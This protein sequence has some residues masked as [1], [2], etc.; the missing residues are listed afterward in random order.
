MKRLRILALMH[1]DL[2][3]PAD[4]TGADMMMVPWK[5]EYDVLSALRELGHEVLPLGVV[6]DLAQIRDAVEEVRPHIAFNLLEQ[7]DGHAIYDQ[8]V[9]AYLELLGVAYTGC[10]PRGL[11]LG[12]DKALSKKVLAYHRIPCPRFLVCRWG[13]TVRLPKRFSYPVIVK[14][15][16]EDS[17]WGISQAS[18]VHSDD[19]LQ[20]RV[21]FLQ[22]KTGDDAIIEQYIEG[23]ELYVSVVGNQRL[24]VFPVWELKLDELAADAYPIATERVKFNRSYREKYNIESCRADLPAELEARI[25]KL[26]KRVYRALDLSGYGRIDVRLDA[27]LRP[28]VLEVNPNP[29]IGYGE[30]L[31]ES[32]HSAGISYP[33]LLQRILNLGLRWRARLGS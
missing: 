13:R 32:A 30:E 21:V 25:Q 22:E 31:A 23:R 29:D 14:A 26:A 6:S 17:S 28:W 5:T 4:A 19:K 10:N 2:V 12:R 20:E 8:N 33:R 1:S 27:D 24:E 11:I 7:F 3:P 16:K 9:V 15:L 18:V